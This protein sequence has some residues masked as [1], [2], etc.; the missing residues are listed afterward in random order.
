MEQKAK[1]VVLI[2]LLGGLILMH[3]AC[4]RRQPY[5]TPPVSGLDIVIDTAQLPLETP[6]FYTYRS[7]GKNIN[8]FVLRMQDKILAFCDACVTC[9][10]KKMGYRPEDGTVICRA[11][12]QRFPIAKLEKG[13]GGC[14]PIKLDGRWDKGT[15]RIA[16]SQ[17]EQMAD[18]F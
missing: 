17:L 18:K 2:A 10:P 4:T 12:G 8:F 16:V 11:C 15:Y 5:P 9:Y 1:N 6:V 13:V 14:Y 3:P 7:G